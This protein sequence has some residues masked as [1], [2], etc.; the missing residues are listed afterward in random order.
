MYPELSIAGV[1]IPM[2][3]LWIFAFLVAFYFMT[4]KYVKQ[5]NLSFDRFAEY[6]PMYIVSIYIISS[7]TW[8]LFKYM[9]VIPLSMSD[10]FE[11]ISPVWYEFHLVGI[12]AWIIIC[13]MHFLKDITDKHIQ[14]KRIDSRFLA[15]SVAIIP[16][17]IFLLLWDN[18][19]W[20]ESNAWYSISALTLESNLSTYGAVIPLWLVISLLWV[21]SYLGIKFR[22]LHN[23]QLRGYGVRWFS[24]LSFILCLIILMQIYPRHGVTDILWVTRDIKNYLLLWLSFR[25]T[26]LWASIY[27]H[28]SHL[29]K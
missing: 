7:Y 13:G 14:V 17:G 20:M 23:A 27:A 28:F 29:K 25:F 12:V 11:Y 6:F 10:I 4:K 1:I 15:I 9:R 18:F 24:I 22:R 3:G 16:L 8:Y 5:F 26:R 2:T 19:I 21:I